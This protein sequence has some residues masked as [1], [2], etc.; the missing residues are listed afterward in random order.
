MD[1]DFVERILNGDF[2]NHSEE[3]TEEDEGMEY[4]A[5]FDE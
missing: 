1:D 5:D 4:D 2:E 3:E